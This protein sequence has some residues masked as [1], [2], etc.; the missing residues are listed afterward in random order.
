M[1]GVQTSKQACRQ[2]RKQA[3]PTGSQASMPTGPQ[4]SHADRFASKLAH[5]RG[6]RRMQ[7]HMNMPAC[8]QAPSR[9]SM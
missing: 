8:E 2:G 1:Q 3:M 9:Q 6:I 4:V 7:I 5:C